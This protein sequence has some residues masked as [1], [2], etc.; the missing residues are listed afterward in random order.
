M[1]RA[2]RDPA[3]KYVQGQTDDDAVGP[4]KRGLP[5][6][7]QQEQAD[8]DRRQRSRRVRRLVHGSGRAD[9][10]TPHASEALADGCVIE[11]GEQQ[12]VQLADIL[13][14]DGLEGFRPIR[15]CE[16]LP[17]VSS[18]RERAPKIG[19]SPVESRWRSP[20]TEA[21]PGGEAGRASRRGCSSKRTHTSMRR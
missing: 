11:I 6:S 4:P 19:L 21:Y 5:A 2:R 13:I 8:R 1:P 3:Q 15:R 18:P 9:A 10:R 7:W 16:E 14:E 12:V 20:S 17:A